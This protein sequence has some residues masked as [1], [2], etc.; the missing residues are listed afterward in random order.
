MVPLRQAARAASLLL[1]TGYC[2][3]YF[4][5]TMFWSLWRP[6][7]T[8]LTR[9]GG[10]LFYGLLGYMLMAV[11]AALRVRTVWALLVA[12]ACFGWIGEGVFAM[13]LFGA[14]GIPFP[15]TIAWTALAWH[16][17]LSVVVGWWW[18]GRALRAPRPWQ[19]L[20]LSAALGLFWGFW[21]YGWQFETPPV[22]AEPGDFF[23]NAMGATLLLALAH[24]AIAWGAPARFRPGRVGLALAAAATLIFFGALTIPQVP[25]APL[26][27]LPLLVLSVFALSRAA[28]HVPE[29]APSVL[30]DFAAPVRWRNLVML[31]VLPLSATALYTLLGEHR[32]Q[33]QTHLVLAALSSLAGTML[34]AVALW[35][36]IRS[37]A[38]AP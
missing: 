17:L 24:A 12:G 1:G 27:L 31:P 7:E 38:A 16:A 2:L 21:A 23:G 32:P 35:R 10:I 37:P 26:M 34:F 18:L 30:A 3:F 22:A 4:S 20:L 13:T 14:E 29:G 25:L 36:T 6:D 5:E 19:T 33:V 15:F 8:P 11:V 28:R 9:I